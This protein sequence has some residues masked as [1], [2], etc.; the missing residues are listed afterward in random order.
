L[1][2][3]LKSGIVDG[4]DFVPERL[5]YYSSI[6]YKLRIGGEYTAPKVQV[7][8]ETNADVPAKQDGL[9]DYRHFQSTC[10][11]RGPMTACRQQVAHVQHSAGIRWRAPLYA[12]DELKEWYP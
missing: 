11:K 5:D 10:P 7:I 12:E 3:Q 4:C 8:L 2:T 1:K 9:R 6:L